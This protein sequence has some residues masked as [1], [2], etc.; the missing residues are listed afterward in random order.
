[1]DLADKSRPF[2]EYGVWMGLS[3]K[4]LI[5]FFG[6]GFSFDTSSGLPEHWN[7]KIKR[8]YSSK[9]IIPEIEDG[10]FIVGKF[11]NTFLTFFQRN[12]QRFL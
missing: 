2:Y 3:F 1:M 8:T 11:E 6:K 4:Y 12:A 10:D 7:Y 9:G 5:K